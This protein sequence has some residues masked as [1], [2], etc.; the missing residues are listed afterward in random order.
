[1]FT[2]VVELPQRE[3]VIVVL[4]TFNDCAI[5]VNESKRGC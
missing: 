3:M 2:S 5:A 1:M 4:E